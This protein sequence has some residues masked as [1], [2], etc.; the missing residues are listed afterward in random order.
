MALY[1]ALYERKCRYP[2][3][4]MEV[5]DKSLEDPELIRETSEKIPFNTAEAENSV[6]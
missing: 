1:E 2:L 6:Q 5:G 3:C 4:W